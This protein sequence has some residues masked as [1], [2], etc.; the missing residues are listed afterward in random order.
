MTA[1]PA[2]AEDYARARRA[3]IDSQLR[4]SEVNDPAVLT[5]MDRVPRED[6]VPAAARGHAYIDRAIPLENGALA[7][8]LVQGR[9]LVEARIAPADRVLVVTGGSDYL[10]ALVRAMGAACDAIDAPTAATRKGKGVYDL[11]LV[12]GALEVVPAP[13]AAQLVD[14]GRMVTGLVERGVTRLAV[15][16]KVAGSVALLPLAEIGMPVLAALAAPKGWSF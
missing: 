14:R 3:M 7:A 12:D 8:P 1:M 2:P 9:M 4:V 11:V 15:G 13:L 5:A 6:Y 16:R 10:P